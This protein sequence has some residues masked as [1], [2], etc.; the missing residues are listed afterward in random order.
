MATG[1]YLH[2]IDTTLRDGEQAAG[3]VF[4]RSDKIA[5]ARALAEARVPELEVG[6]PAMG[7]DVI[8]DINA[9]ADAVAGGPRIITWCR[10]TPDDLAAARHCRVAGVHL[11]FPVSEIH[12]RIWKKNPSG[13]LASLR[14][15]TVAALEHFSQVTVGAQDASR[16]DPGFLAEFAAAV[17]DT[18]AVRLRIADT[19]GTLSPNRTTTLI[20]RLRRAAPSLPLEMHAHND[21]GLANANT[22]AAFFAG[23]SSAS[24]TVNGLGERAGNAALEEVVMALKIAEGIDCG[25]DTTR[26]AALSALVARASARPVPPEKP[27]VG[28][29]AFLHESGIHCAGQLRDARSYEAFSPAS[30]GRRVSDFVLGAHTGGSAVA[31]M[32][33][34]RGIEVTTT[35]ARSLAAHVRT[36]ARRR[37]GPLTPAEAQTIYGAATSPSPDAHQR[38]LCSFGDADVAAP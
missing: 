1:E 38:M 9:V 24:V 2:L 36:L 5:I 35:A 30:V 21:L 19:V 33:R 20:A 34:A 32:M 22:L 14:E 13:I 25:I 7:T 3:V 29:S 10:A 31:A 12:L 18:P 28:S 26:F 27:I 4:T 23:A 17:A 15:L 11:S 16:A 8:D 6:I 37:G